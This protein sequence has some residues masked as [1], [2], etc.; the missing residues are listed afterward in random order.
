MER[1]KNST[2]SALPT[3]GSQ[4]LTRYASVSSA[5]AASKANNIARELTA[6]DICASTCHTQRRCSAK[7]RARAVRTPCTIATNI[8][9]PVA[10]KPSVDASPPFAK[11]D[12]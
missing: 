2:A 6:T 7:R 4:R 5:P 3:T 11:K 9:P 12:R 1:V 8:T 10:R